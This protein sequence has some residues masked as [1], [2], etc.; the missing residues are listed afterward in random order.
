M[1]TIID[2]VR[3]ATIGSPGPQGEPGVAG[4]STDVG[5]MAVLGTDDLIFVPAAA[6]SGVEE[7]PL[8]GGPYGRQAAAWVEAVGPA[9]PAGPAGSDGID[10]AQ[11]PQGIQGPAGADGAQGP[12]GIQGPA[13]ADG[14]QG[15]QGIQGP[16]GAEGAQGPQGVQ[17][18]AGPSAVS[19]DAGNTATLGTDDLIYVPAAG[20]G[21]TLNQFMLMGA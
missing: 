8:V 16:A 4:I 12:Q 20:G 17:G 5:N 15:P 3:I 18:P 7:A 13:G 11:G 9:G 21:E 6:V 10:G 19:T 14:A 2:T 1:I